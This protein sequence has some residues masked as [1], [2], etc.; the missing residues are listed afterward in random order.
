[1]IARPLKAALGLLLLA[2]AASSA[3]PIQDSALQ[4]YK[5]GWYPNGYKEKLVTCPEIC[6][7]EVNGVAEH[8]RSGI[9]RA[10]AIYVCRVLY[11]PG[12]PRPLLGERYSYG[13]QVGTEA[14]CRAA[15]ASGRIME[16]KEFH[17]LC[18]ADKACSGPDLVVSRIDRP[19]WDAANHRSV[20]TAEIRNV[21]TADAAPSIARV[22]DPSTIQPSS[23]APYNAIANTPLLA[24]GASVIVTFDL[25]YWVFNPD[26]ELEVT[27]DYKGMVQ[28]CNEDNNVK[29]FRQQ[30]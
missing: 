19:V 3:D 12:A 25:P 2:A 18:I 24:A 30:G 21:G 1:M 15:N 13:N 4:D 9:L 23:G 8:E 6:K 27:A 17:C 29:T 7:L 10:P 5:A 22:I 14:V 11:R 16:V 26:A 28:E 20:I